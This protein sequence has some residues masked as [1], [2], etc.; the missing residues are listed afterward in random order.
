[1]KIDTTRFGELE[2][3]PDA[4]LTFPRGLT[5]LENCK[6]YQL[7]HEMHEDKTSPVVHYLQSLDDA[8]VAFSIVDPAL[9]GFNYELTLSDEEEALLQADNSTD[10]AVL[11]MVYK[12][13]GSEDGTAVSGRHQRQY[14]WAS[15]AK[16]GQETG[17]AKSAGGGQ[18]RHY[19]AGFW[20]CLNLIRKNEYSQRRCGAFFIAGSMLAPGC[21]HEIC[22]AV[23]NI[24]MRRICVQFIGFVPQKADWLSG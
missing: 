21:P 3:N 16:F 17:I 23:L 18:I 24:F 5:G 14:Q 22:W 10:L 20:R 9:F 11:L 4:I 2:I 7:L 1:M 19:P 15:G 6:R 13:M 12:P 8:A